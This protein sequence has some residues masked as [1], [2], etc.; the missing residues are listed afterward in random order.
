MTVKDLLAHP[1]TAVAVVVSAIGQ[2]GFGAF[3]PAWSL[4]SSTSGYWF[5]ALATTSS[6]ILP[7]VGYGEL[8]SKLLVA[9]AILFVGV[10]VD[11][12]IAKLQTWKENR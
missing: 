1:W 5:P 11:R 10:Q 12:L 9:G 4:I 7:E 2:V 3:E 6:T 8:G